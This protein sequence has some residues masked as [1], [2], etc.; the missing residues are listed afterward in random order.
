MGETKEI[1]DSVFKVVVGLIL[2]ITFTAG[3]VVGLLAGIATADTLPAGTWAGEINVMVTEVPMEQSEPMP[4]P[5][6]VLDPVWIE[7]TPG[8]ACVAMNSGDETRRDCYVGDGRALP[9]WLLHFN[10]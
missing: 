10:D 8:D 9:D 3:I 5:P 6:A 7:P 2:A 4:P 1:P